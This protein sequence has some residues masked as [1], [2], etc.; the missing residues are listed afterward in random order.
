[1]TPKHVEIKHQHSLAPLL[2]AMMHDAQSHHF[3]HLIPVRL[4]FRVNWSCICV[5]QFAASLPYTRHHSHLSW[6]IR[7]NRLHVLAY[8]ALCLSRIPAHPATLM[9]EIEYSLSSSCM[10]TNRVWHNI[11]LEGECLFPRQ[12]L[13]VALES[14]LHDAD[15]Q[16]TD[17]IQSK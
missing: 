16:A 1:M 12:L 6:Y 10:L 13:L 5:L 8:L 17:Y 3:Q 2:L 11:K 9:H 14:V 4:A 7:C 15:N